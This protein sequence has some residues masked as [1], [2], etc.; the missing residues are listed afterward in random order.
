MKPEADKYIMTM[1]GNLL[2]NFMPSLG[3]DM[4]KKTMAQMAY[5]MIAATEDFDRGASRRIEE[6]KQLRRLFA[7][8]IPVVTDQDLIHRLEKASNS[9]E[10]DFKVSALDKIN[11]DFRALFIDLHRHVE[12]MENEK[13]AALEKKLWIELAASVKR[14]EY[15]LWT[16]L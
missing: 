8:A 1:A 5:L 12:T 13:A 16:P 11:Q 6:N 9:T 7:E 15:A 10:E 4:E 14:R 2:M 3:T